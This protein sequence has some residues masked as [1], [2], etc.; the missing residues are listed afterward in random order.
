MEEVKA[1]LVLAA[2]V[3][4]PLG[5]CLAVVRVAL[6][7]AD[8]IALRFSWTKKLVRII[9]SAVSLLVLLLVLVGLIVAFGA[10]ANAEANTKATMLARGISEV[11]ACTP[12]VVTAAGTAAGVIS[13]VV[14]TRRWTRRP[15]ASHR[16]T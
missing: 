10:V 16:P 13:L 8:R 11:L 15:P 9:G 5:I 4:V 3:L 6:Y 12:L 7:V 14:V 2:L 1:I